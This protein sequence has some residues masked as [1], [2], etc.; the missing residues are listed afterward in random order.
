MITR[1]KKEIYSVNI[2]FDE[3]SEVWKAN[4]KSMGNGTYK[5]ICCATTLSGKQCKR[6]SILF[7][8]YCKIHIQKNNN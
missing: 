7:E 4:K 6:E 1:S 3:A 5:Y 2:N 8:E